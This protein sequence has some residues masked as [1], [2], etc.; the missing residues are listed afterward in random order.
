MT[1]GKEFITIPGFERIPFIYHGFGTSA[2][3]EE[4]FRQG[5]EWTG[6]RLIHLKQLH[7]DIIHTI[8]DV[9]DTI[10]RGDALITALPGLFLIIKSADCVPV[11]LVDEKKRVI[12][13]VHCGWKGTLLRLLDK[14]VSGMKTQFGS[15]PADILAGFGP[16]IGATCYDVG[17]EVRNAFR[18]NGFPDALFLPVPGRPLKYFFDLRKANIL[19]LRRQ[20]LRDENIFSV[21]ICPHCDCRFPSFRRDRTNTGRMLSFIAL[22]R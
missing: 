22:S 6:Y 8:L 2:W 7:S 19:Q 13:A 18:E 9:P 1:Q 20:G 16:S 12:A 17:E 15:V 3:K 21:D 5:E 14:V 4:D 11:L 10:L